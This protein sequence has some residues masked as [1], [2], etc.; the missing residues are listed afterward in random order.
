MESMEDL[1][2]DEFGTSPDLDTFSVSGLVRAAH[3]GRRRRRAWHSGIG[4]A[5][6]LL[7]VAG[8]IAL[9]RR[10]GGVEP[11]H[12]SD[13][14]FLDA[15]EAAAYG[16]GMPVEGTFLD[17]RH[18]WVVLERCWQVDYAGPN[19][20]REQCANVLEVT[21]DGG[22]TFT[23]HP[24]PTSLDPSSFQLYV[25]DAS[26][27]VLAE[28]VTN[29]NTAPP[30]F[31]VDRARWTSSDGGATWKPVSLALG[32]PLDSIPTGAQILV[33]G[34]STNE[35]I[36]VL[37]A[38][39]VAHVLTPAA[40]YP[41]TQVVYGSIIA[42]MSPVGPVGG[43]FYLYGQTGSGYSAR[44]SHDQGRTWPSS[45]L[46]RNEMGI[47]VIGSDGDWTY[48]IGIDSG[49]GPPNLYASHDGL[50]WQAVPAPRADTNANGSAHSP[51][52]ATLPSVGLLVDDG[53]QIW[54]TVGTAGLTAV[55]DPVETRNLIGCGPT[56]VAL[57]IDRGGTI[58][59]AT[60][61]DGVHWTDGK[62]G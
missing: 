39:G 25:F 11:S 54:R 14:V 24:L 5:V 1:L 19:Q 18:G 59:I 20:Q 33:N 7:L 2:R 6:A 36:T 29:D 49:F 48:A 22:A 42:P 50:D 44:V 45:H 51:G 37:T 21:T 27:L 9:G 13:S 38:D 3:A 56:A 23:E 47:V 16:Y 4:I 8:G 30:P 31:M 41:A 43:A 35:P 15:G 46:P 60:T 26:H 10:S 17:A 32:S 40:A 52:Y 28:N 12:Q 53:A 62:I 55:P 58:T 57:R 61:S 34:P